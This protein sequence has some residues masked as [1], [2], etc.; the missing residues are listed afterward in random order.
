[1]F[2]IGDF[3]RIANLSIHQLRHYDE[4]GLFKPATTDRMTG[5]RYYR[6]E[7]LPRLHRIVALKNLGLTLDQVKRLLDDDVSAGDIRGMLLLKKVQV[8]Q[9][10]SEEVNRLHQIEA[11]LHH[12]EAEGESPAY[13][14]VVKSVP[15][16]QFLS[17]RHVTMSDAALVRMQRELYGILQVREPNTPFPMALIH[18][19]STDEGDH[20]VEVGY[21]V[22]KPYPNG[23]TLTSG[24][25]MTMRTLPAIEAM[26]TTIYEGSR[27]AMG[28]AYTA[29]FRWIDAN[30]YQFGPD[31]F[32]EVYLQPTLTDTDPHNIVELQIPITRTT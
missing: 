18:D 10:I 8:E 22:E 5:Y 25:Q 27:R 6:L 4:V 29:L 12:I 2:K 3:A 23:I 15:E 1:M 11:R 14:V 19:A 17:S 24:F 7:Q 32:R 28:E 20:N 30:H 9:T 16:V 21:A 13:G 31:N 26:A